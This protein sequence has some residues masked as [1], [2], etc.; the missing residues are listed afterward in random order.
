M[1]VHD[2]VVSKH[3]IFPLRN[4]ICSLTNVQEIEFDNLKDKKNIGDSSYI[5]KVD[6]KKQKK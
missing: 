6:L 3:L 2:T 4:F 5:I 1:I